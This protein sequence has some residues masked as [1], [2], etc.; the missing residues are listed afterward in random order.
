MQPILHRGL[1]AA[2]SFAALALSIGSAAAQSPV[3]ETVTTTTTTDGVV[4][5]YGPQSVVI[6]ASDS[7]TP[8]R[9]VF[10]EST[11]Y[12]NELGQPVSAS[13][14]QAGKPVAIH[15]VREGDALV[16][17][18]VIVR[19]SP[20]P[21]SAVTE[22]T[23]STT[24]T[25]F[26]SSY[27]PEGLGVRIEASTDPLFY[28]LARTTTYVD[29]AGAP[30]AVETLRSGLPVTVYYTRSPDGMLA[31]KVVVQR[32]AAVVTPAAPAPVIERTTTT[33]RTLR[34]SED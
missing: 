24:V 2:V 33:T 7:S 22:T 1:V 18:K 29:D 11:T 23:A 28:N 12:V 5:E 3:V 6:T 30:V 9:Y 16:A 15:Y 10:R 32:A 21:V 20:A 13:V 34:T 31:S 14:I 25:G 4:R 26:I 19:N 8:A 27:G 17:A